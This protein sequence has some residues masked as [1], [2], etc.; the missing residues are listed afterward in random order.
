[1]TFDESHCQAGDD[2]TSLRQDLSP[3]KHNQHTSPSLHRSWC[4]LIG[5]QHKAIRALVPQLVRVA[6][7]RV[8][9]GINVVNT[10]PSGGVK[11]AAGLSDGV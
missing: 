10:G 1:M 8:A 6:V 5:R 11:R 9:R 4:D 7:R 3:L 2:F